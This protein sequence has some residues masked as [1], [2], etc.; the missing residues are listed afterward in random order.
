MKT[1]SRGRVRREGQE[2]G[3]RPL[4]PRLPGEWVSRAVRIAMP[5]V[6]WAQF[7]ALVARASDGTETA[8]RVN[9]RV[10]AALMD[11]QSGRGPHWLDWEREK[12]QR[13]LAAAGRAA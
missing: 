13:L 4:Y 11:V 1:D 12:A 7:D 3:L 8:A 6:R 5:A 2:R 9:G 10:L